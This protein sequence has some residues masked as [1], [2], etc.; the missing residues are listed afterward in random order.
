M[1]LDIPAPAVTTVEAA[2]TAPVPVAAALAPTL[3]IENPA[4]AATPAPSFVSAGTMKAE[5][6]LAPEL[7]TVD[8][9]RSVENQQIKEV[10]KA[11]NAIQYDTA[12]QHVGAGLDKQKDKVLSSDPQVNVDQSTKAGR[13][14]A[15]L[16]TQ[17]NKVEN[18]HFAGDVQRVNDQ[19]TY[20][21]SRGRAAQLS[22][23]LSTVNWRRNEVDIGLAKGL[24]TQAQLEKT[25]QVQ[26]AVATTVIRKATQ[27]GAVAASQVDELLAQPQKTSARGINALE[28]LNAQLAA[29]PIKADAPVSAAATDRVATAAEVKAATAAMTSP[30]VTARAESSNSEAPAMAAQS[31]TSAAMSLNQ[32]TPV[33]ALTPSQ[34][35]LHTGL[36]YQS[37][38][39]DGVS[40]GTSNRA[41]GA[42]SNTNVQPET[43]LAAAPRM[44]VRE[45]VRPSSPTWR[46][47]NN[48][49]VDMPFGF[50]PS[51]SAPKAVRDAVLIDDQKQGETI[52]NSGSID[53]KLTPRSQVDTVG[54]PVDSL[55]ARPVDFY[56]QQA[57]NKNQLNAA[58]VAANA[59]SLAP[60]Q[61]RPQAMS[62]SS[63]SMSQRRSQPAMTGLSTST[64]SR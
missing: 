53:L 27:P 11:D 54:K 16:K 18:T 42:W 38:N 57:E 62:S 7:P 44:P 64:A 59:A 4:P 9:R 5:A 28:A 34:E 3:K 15:A 17:Q 26:P 37:V 10:F 40:L 30:F 39:P 25:A 49:A 32:S 45:E 58:P 22:D 23:S 19:V 55:L 2:K 1:P 48:D 29:A 24:E 43:Q 31:R 47:F 63:S 51:V 33:F 21:T 8:L 61:Q 6:G 46:L 41:Q 36:V 20:D 35:P 12:I 52:Q 50:M 13:D 60:S 56:L 14:L